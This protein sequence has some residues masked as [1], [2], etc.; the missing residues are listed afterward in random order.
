[1]PDFR[2]VAGRRRKNANFVGSRPSSCCAYDYDERLRSD[3]QESFGFLALGGVDLAGFDP[4]A[5]LVAL[6]HGEARN[7]EVARDVA[8]NEGDEACVTHDAKKQCR[9]D[10]K[11]RVRW[12][13]LNKRRTANR[14]NKRLDLE[15]AG[16][17]AYHPKSVLA[18]QSMAHSASHTHV[19]SHTGNGDLVTCARIILPT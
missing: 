17:S 11:C 9:V 15:P 19:Q 12:R 3:W 14:V 13:R 5:R 10:E 18:F 4:L 8:D 6:A 7:A 1:M 16:E 2:C